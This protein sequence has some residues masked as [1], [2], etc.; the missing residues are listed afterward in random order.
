M[1]VF[2]FVRQLISI[3]TFQKKDMSLSDRLY[4]RMFCTENDKDPSTHFLKN[5]PVIE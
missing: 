1:K 5:P 3:F 2:K 4:L